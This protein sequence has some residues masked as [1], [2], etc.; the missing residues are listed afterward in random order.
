MINEGDRW[1]LLNLSCHKQCL[2]VTT[3]KTTDAVSASMREYGGGA[4]GWAECCR[5]GAGRN[6]HAENAQLINGDV[7]YAA[8]CLL[9]LTVVGRTPSSSHQANALG[10]LQAAAAT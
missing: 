10:K 6:L 8:A 9:I 1:K 3:D 5:Q 4:G 7:M 2:A